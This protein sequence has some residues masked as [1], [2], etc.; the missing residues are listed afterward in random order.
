MPDEDRPLDAES[1]EQRRQHVVGLVVHVPDRPRLDH[2]VA[3]AVT[4]AGVDDDLRV[5][6][7]RAHVVGE[8]AP[9]VERPEAFVQEH[10]RRAL[11]RRTAGR[12]DAHVDGAAA[13]GEELAAQGAAASC[14][15]RA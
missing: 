3:A 1:I 13:D 12:L 7:R 14:S 8:R 2:G 11:R 15:R 6:G 9:E 5:A 10:Q 4:V